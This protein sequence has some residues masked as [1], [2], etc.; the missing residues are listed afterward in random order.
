[1][2][3]NIINTNFNIIYYN[4]IIMETELHH[5]QQRNRPNALLSYILEQLSIFKKFKNTYNI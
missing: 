4:D 1:M 2:K 3:L 5:L